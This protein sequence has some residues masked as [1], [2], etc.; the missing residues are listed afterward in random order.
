MFV[1]AEV[2]HRFGINIFPTTLILSPEGNLMDKI[3]GFVAP[4]EFQRRLEDGVLDNNEEIG[5]LNIIL[6]ADVRGSIEAIQ[7][8]LEK[9][10]HPEVRINVLQASVVT[11]TTSGCSG[12]S[13]A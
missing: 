1:D 13:T 5:T 4:Q 12:A 11:S 10:D 2:V 3:D 9:L 8:E 7:K 6:R